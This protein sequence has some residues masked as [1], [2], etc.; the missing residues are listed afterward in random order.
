MAI[1]NLF[2]VLGLPFGRWVIPKNLTHFFYK[3]L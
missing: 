2:I 3:W 1:E